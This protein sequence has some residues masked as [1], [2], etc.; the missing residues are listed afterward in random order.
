DDRVALEIRMPEE[1]VENFSYG[2]RFQ[3]IA[4][5]LLK[6]HGDRY[7]QHVVGNRLLTYTVLDG[8]ESERKRQPAGPSM[9]TPVSDVGSYIVYRAAGSYPLST[10]SFQ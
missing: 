8:T 4:G 10:I 7:K 2:R 9:F 6:Y 1:L 5:Y 3:G